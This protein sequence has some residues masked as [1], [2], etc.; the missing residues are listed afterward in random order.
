MWLW[1]KWIHFILLGR[2]A[3]I[4][5]FCPT[6]SFVS[7]AY[8]I[9]VWRSFPSKIHNSWDRDRWKISFRTL[10]LNQNKNKTWRAFLVSGENSQL[11]SVQPTQKIVNSSAW[12]SQERNLKIKYGNSTQ[13]ET[14]LTKQGKGERPPI[15]SSRTWRHIWQKSCNDSKWST[16]CPEWPHRPRWVQMEWCTWVRSTVR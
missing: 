4:W 2:G 12:K 11:S 3:W 14:Y 16:D 13:E 6:F 5:N 1:K 10:E 15:Q 9:S 8:I 7:L